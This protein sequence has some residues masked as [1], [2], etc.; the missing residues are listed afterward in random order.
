MIPPSAFRHS[1]ADLPGPTGS[2]G[3]PPPAT[4]RHGARSVTTSTSSLLTRP[5]RQAS[6]FF[7]AVGDAGPKP[8]RTPRPISTPSTAGRPPTE[9]GPTGLLGSRDVLLRDVLAKMISWP[10]WPHFFGPK[11][12]AHK[13]KNLFLDATGRYHQQQSNMIAPAG[14]GIPPSFGFL[15]SLKRLGKAK[16]SA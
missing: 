16:I 10:F 4:P 12:L 3:D 8:R 1:P 11:R 9:T 7:C 14:P 5:I 2:R 6:C 15:R 13:P